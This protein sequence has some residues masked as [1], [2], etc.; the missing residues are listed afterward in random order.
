[1]TAAARAVPARALSFAIGFLSLGSE[2]LWI[3]T[4]SF[5]NESMAK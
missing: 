5:H 4:F 3:R 1:M 2:T